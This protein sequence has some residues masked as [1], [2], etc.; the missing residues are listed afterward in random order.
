VVFRGILNGK[1]RVRAHH[2]KL[3]RVVNYSRA[4]GVIILPAWCRQKSKS[5][6]GVARISMKNLHNSDDG[7]GCF[8]FYHFEWNAILGPGRRLQTLG[9]AFKMQAYTLR[10]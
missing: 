6:G 8:S 7:G 5:G 2:R 10:R 4:V 3:A 1:R 9:F